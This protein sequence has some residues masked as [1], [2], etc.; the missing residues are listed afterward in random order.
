MNKIILLIAFSIFISGINS[1]CAKRAD[2]SVKIPLVYRIDIQQGNVIDQEM[3]DKLE[4]GMDK[5][6]VRFIMGT[7]LLQDPFHSNRWE[8]IYSYE[9]GNGNREQRHLAVHFKDDKLTHLDG[10]VKSGFR[11][12]TDENDTEA[13]NVILT[14]ERKKKGLFSNL[15]GSSPKRKNEPGFFDRWFGTDEELKKAD[16]TRDEATD[17]E[18]ESLAEEVND[19]SEDSA[20]PLP[21]R[22]AKKIE[23]DFEVLEQAEDSFGRGQQ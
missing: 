3:I 13:S 7:P 19:R 5:A 18:L 8:Y 17:K 1:G 12:T 4:P 16:E 21:K 23:R 2:G 6:K 10:N 11:H 14:D 22:D 9:P 20:L 15:F